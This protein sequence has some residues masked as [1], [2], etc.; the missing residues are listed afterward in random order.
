MTESIDVELLATICGGQ[1][2][3]QRPP[4]PRTTIYRPAPPPRIANSPLP[5]GAITRPPR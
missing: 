4:L 2:M 3:P 1:F 5:G